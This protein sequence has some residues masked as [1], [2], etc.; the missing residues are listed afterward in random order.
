[1]SSAALALT[2]AAA[3][4]HAGWNVLLAGAR[5]VRAA[6]TVALGLSVLLFAPVAAAT[7]RVEAAAVPW[8]AAS[9][10]LE[11]AYFVL[12][13]RAY[14]RSDVSLVYPIARG[15]APV[16]VLAASVVMGTSLGVAQAAGVLLVG[17]GVVLVR[18]VSRPV[19]QRG[20]AL[21][22][23]IGATI[24][25]YTLVDKQGL[26]HAA[27]LPYLEL[28]LAPVAAAVLLVEARSRRLAAVRAAAG[29]RTIVAAL[30]SFGAYALVLAA[31]TRAPAAAVAAVRETSIVFAVGLSALL[32]RERVDAARA[33]GAALVVAGV[34]VVSLA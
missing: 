5:D 8:I 13:T 21:A 6:T 34:V 15:S 32:L 14:A 19:D 33:L 26:Q 3:V 25:G 16:L 10:A 9:A 28:V 22:V 18:G 2:L 17:G 12:L 7:W 1:V 31:L 4:L 30:A 24:A 23:A 27:V 29:G 20:V 11:L